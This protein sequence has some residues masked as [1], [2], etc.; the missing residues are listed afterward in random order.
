MSIKKPRC[1]NSSHYASIAVKHD[2]LVI[3]LFSSLSRKSPQVTSEV[4]DEDVFAEKQRIEKPTNEANQDILKINQLTKVF[5]R[6]MKE[7]CVA[8]NNISV[9]VHT[10]EVCGLF[11]FQF[12][13]QGS[14]S[15]THC[16]IHF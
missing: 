12:T 6:S 2:F 7:N 1:D 16:G 15:S 11:L 3:V 10:G 5:R 9:G 4:D 8:V 13:Y 14:S